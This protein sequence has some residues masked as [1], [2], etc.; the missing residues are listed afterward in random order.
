MIKGQC[1]TK[2]LE[3]LDS[4]CET[5]SRRATIVAE[6]KRKFRVGVGGG[7]GSYT[8]ER[9]RL[10]WIITLCIFFG[11]LFLFGCVPLLAGFCVEDCRCSN[12]CCK[13]SSNH[14]RNKN[15]L[16]AVRMNN[17]YTIT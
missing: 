6:R 15:D 12:S 13:N 4:N 10:T 16:L 14:R 1:D 17:L 11:G 5:V 9:L 2:V 8:A 7:G 3:Q